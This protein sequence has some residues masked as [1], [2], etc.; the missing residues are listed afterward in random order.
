MDLDVLREYEQFYHAL[1]EDGLISDD[2]EYRSVVS[3]FLLFARRMCTY[4]LA[5]PDCQGARVLD[6]GCYT[7][8]GESRLHGAAEKVTAIDMDPWAIEQA[9]ERWKYPNVSFEV[10]D[11]RGLPFEDGT[12]DVALAVHLIE[13]V[14]PSELPAFL[15]EVKRVLADG[16]RLIA[17]T[18]N[19]KFR[20]YPGERS[21]HPEHFK[22][23]TSSSL[24]KALELE[25]SSTRVMGVCAQGWIEDIERARVKRSAFRAYVKK[26]LKG[27]AERILPRDA[28]SRLSG[29]AARR[30]PD[31]P[32]RASDPAVA[33]AEF[34]RALEGFSM[35]QFE[36]CGDPRR[37]EESMDLFGIAE[38]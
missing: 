6:I 38:K 33:K 17:I 9:R 18:P 7:G 32:A 13:H 36:L 1:L 25:F 24:R 31:G 20:L 10:A 15:G 23:Y 34:D 8:Y 14:R 28:A 30:K 22:E 2:S 3:G 26:P 27:A 19:R 16:G 37:V 11:A 12:F 4:D 29:W 21:S 5:A 35:D